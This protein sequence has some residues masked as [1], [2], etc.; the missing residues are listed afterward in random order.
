M[1]V[2][3]YAIDNTLVLLIGN[4][5]IMVDNM[6]NRTT[7]DYD[8]YN[9]VY[10][11]IHVHLIANPPGDNHPIETE[12][13]QL[14]NS[15]NFY[16]DVIKDESYRTRCHMTYYLHGNWTSVENNKLACDGTTFDTSVVASNLS[17]ALRTVDYNATVIKV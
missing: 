9:K 8:T 6:Y 17:G 14:V 1:Q 3:K 16:N 15:C 2:S 4:P 11:N 5:T 13:Q 12:I 7:R 10:K